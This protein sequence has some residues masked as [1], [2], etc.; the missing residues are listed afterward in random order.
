MLHIGFQMRPVF[1]FFSMMV[2][3][4]FRSHLPTQSSSVKMCADLLRKEAISAFR[5]DTVPL[6]TL[7]LTVFSDLPEPA[8]QLI[9]NTSAYNGSGINNSACRFGLK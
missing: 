9:I 6:P 7:F 2:H 1:F 3:V 8:G 5:S 4:L